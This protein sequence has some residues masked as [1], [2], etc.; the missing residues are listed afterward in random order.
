MQPM[1]ARIEHQV[2]DILAHAGISGISGASIAVIVDDQM[3]SA[4]I[5]SQDLEG[6]IPLDKNAR[7][8]IYSITK[9]FIAAAILLLV[10]SGNLTIDQPVLETLPEFALDP[11]ITLRLLLSH[12]AGIPDYAGMTRYA[13]DLI[14]DPARPWTVTQFLDRSLSLGVGFAP[15]QG[16]SYSNIG[17]LLLK[18]VLER[19]TAMSLRASLAHLVID[20]IGLKQTEVIETLDNAVNLTPG[21]SS[22]LETDNSLRDIS[23]RYHP[24]W[25]SHGLI[26]STAADVARFFDALLRGQLLGS[27]SLRLMLDPVSVPFVHRYFTKPSYGLGL[28]LDPFSRL[29][30]IAGHGGEGPGYSAAAL[31]VSPSSGDGFTTVAL[32]N[33]DVHDL[34]MEIAWTMATILAERGAR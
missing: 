5:G 7:F 27:A 30:P 1:S 12:T 18:L 22:Q 8:P 3:W 17:F 10:E 15:G 14:R 19:R 28:M 29:G 11:A 31:H 2:A 23:R 32:V 16:W 6:T 13:G 26:A 21:F 20:P 4:A 33:Q 25:V 34:G 9:T 24:G